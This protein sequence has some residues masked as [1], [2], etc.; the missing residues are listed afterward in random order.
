MT[1][2]QNSYWSGIQ[3]LESPPSS[4]NLL[5]GDS[6]RTMPSPSGYVIGSRGAESVFV[7]T[8]T[9]QVAF[10]ARTLQVSGI[11]MKVQA[12]DTA[13]TESFRSL[14]RSYFR[15]T[16]CEFE[17]VLCDIK[18]A[19]SRALQVRSLYTISLGGRRS[20]TSNIGWMSANG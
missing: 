14:T 13:G 19:V 7:I 10:G 4:F 8:T 3:R 1:V 2:R 17:C 15:G 20:V 9:T 16:A 5:M 11:K 18:Q 6:A 12:W